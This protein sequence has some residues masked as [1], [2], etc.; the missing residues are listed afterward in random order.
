MVRAGHRAASL[1][2]TEEAQRYFE[3]AAELTAHPVERAELLEHAGA[4][5]QRG[6][7]GDAGLALYDE[8]IR[9]FTEAGRTHPAARASARTAEMLWQNEQIDEAIRRMQDAYTVLAE[10]E[11]DADFA[12]LLAELSR[13]LFFRGETDLAI[14]RVD[15]ALEIAE[16][17]PLPETISQGLN[18]KHLG[19]LT[20]GRTEEALALLKHSLQ[21]ALDHDLPAAGLRAYVNLSNLMDELM[22][23]DEAKA[24]QTDGIALARRVGIRW[25]EWWLLGHLVHTYAYLGEWDAAEA[26]AA[27][28]P[29][30]DEISDA[31]IGTSIAGTALARILAARGEIQRA[32]AMIERLWLPLL[33]SSDV[34]TAASAAASA[35]TVDVAAGRHE[36]ALRRAQAGL[37]HVE[38]LGPNHA[39][40]RE[41]WVNAM[42]ASLALGDLETASRVFAAMQ[43][44]PGGH[45]HAYV[46]AQM[47]RFGAALAVAR[48]DVEGIEP[49][50]TAAAAIFGEA[51]CVFDRAE[52]QAEHHEWLVQQGLSE[53]EEARALAEEAEAVFSRLGAT[54][55]LERMTRSRVAMPAG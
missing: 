42:A 31:R 49:G 6:G 25:A 9:L 22:R 55:W 33:D 15:R 45:I 13:F 40:L 3:R 53:S 46:R 41:C 48:G 14:E 20:R 24:Y 19:F 27:E 17:I 51:G 1:A 10:E 50:F 36:Q 37:V 35:S 38:G 44:R 34:Q 7:R 11:P 29:D 18:T 30:P 52:V 28:I 26:T 23:L 32:E 2:A 21:V 8:A 39:S 12:V 16:A 4:M 43:S 54:V 47:A 5:A